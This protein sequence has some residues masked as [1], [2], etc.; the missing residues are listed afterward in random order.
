MLRA[1]NKPQK[2]EELIE[3]FPESDF[4]KIGYKNH[5]GQEI[6]SQEKT[7]AA[8]DIWKR[9]SANKGAV[10]GLSILAI[11]ALF[12]IIGP[13]ISGY[14]YNEAIKGLNNVPARIP[15]LSWIN[16]FSGSEK[17]IDIYAAKD[18]S[19]NFWFGTDALGRDLFTRVWSGTRISFIIAFAAVMI[20][21]VIGVTYGTISGFFGGKVD[22]VMQRFLEIVNGIPSLVV[23]TLFVIVFEPGMLTIILSLMLTGWIGMSRVVRSQVLKY[24]EQEF[25]LASEVLG[26]NKL[27]II[28]KEIIPNIIGQ[29]IVMTMFSIPNA[30]FYEAYLAFV[31]LGL[32]EPQASLGKLINSG[33]ESMLT[34]PHLLL[35]PVVVLS[36]LMLSFNL[37]ADGL[38]DAIDPK[39]KGF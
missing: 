7:S 37:V 12:T 36:L 29:M 9:F 18:I 15:F 30:I 35:F 3:G 14:R 39:M 38:R 31:G 11:I 8:G 17:G 1:Q 6:H 4:E 23:V 22:M 28:M 32:S 2:Y 33:Y 25:V 21:F 34:H 27:V 20:D 19:Q 13:M 5:A 26:A 24:K 10:I 16:F